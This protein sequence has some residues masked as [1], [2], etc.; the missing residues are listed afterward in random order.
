MG[1]VWFMVLVDKLTKEIQFCT[2]NRNCPTLNFVEISCT[3]LFIENILHY[4]FA[5]YIFHY[6][7][8]ESVLFELHVLLIPLWIHSGNMGTICS[9]LSLPQSSGNLMYIKICPKILQPVVYLNLG[10]FCKLFYFIY[11]KQDLT[12]IKIYYIM[13]NWQ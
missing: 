3:S 10:T 6:L 9:L 2:L 12:Y 8:L 11:F 5:E 4:L 7:T 1:Y 13:S